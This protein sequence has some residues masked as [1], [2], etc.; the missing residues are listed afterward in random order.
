[1][2]DLEMV[3][4]GSETVSLAEL[5]GIDFS[6]VKEQRTFVFPV[7]HY[8]WQVSS[9]PEPPK[10]KKLGDGAAIAFHLKCLNVLGLKE[11]GELKPDDLVGQVHR[12]TFFISKLEDYGFVKAFMV[13][14][15]VPAQSGTPNDLGLACVDRKFAAPIIH[16]TNRKDKDAPP[17]VNINRAKGKII[18]YI[19]KAA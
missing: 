1:M 2:S 10:L 16:T 8:L 17:Y 15:G 9:E 13:D 12:E 7:G 6:H 18:P 14:I 3:Q 4:L 11:G 19:Q 5:A